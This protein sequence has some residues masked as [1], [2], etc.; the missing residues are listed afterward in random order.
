MLAANSYKSLLLPLLHNGLAGEPTHETKKTPLLR[1]SFFAARTTKSA[2]L[3]SAATPFTDTHDTL[4]IAPL[5]ALS[6]DRDDT[7]AR[8][9][10]RFQIPIAVLAYDHEPVVVQQRRKLLWE[11]IA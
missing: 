4:V 3:C 5:R 8:G 10:Q 9:G 11:G 7:R 6:A 1:F 2:A